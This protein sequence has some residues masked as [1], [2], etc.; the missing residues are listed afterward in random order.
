MPRRKP[1][2]EKLHRVTGFKPAIPLDQTI[3]NVAQ[4]L[5]AAP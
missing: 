1:S 5:R 3:L 4:T 2:I